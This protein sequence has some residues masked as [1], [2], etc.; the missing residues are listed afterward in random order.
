[1]F[2]KQTTLIAIQ[3]KYG[4]GKDLTTSIIQE[5]LEPDTK[6]Y[7]DNELTLYNQ[8]L[9]GFLL[10]NFD[11]EPY[12]PQYKEYQWQNK[13]FATKLKEIVSMLTGYTLAELEL[14]ETKDI[15]L[16]SYNNI[17]IR[18]L[19]QQ[20]GTNLRAITED[21]WINV[22]FKD[23]QKR[24][25]QRVMKD[26]NGYPYSI[27]TLRNNDHWIISDLRYKN[28][29]KAIKDR[30]GVLIRINRESNIVQQCSTLAH[31]DLLTKF[32]NDVFDIDNDDVEYY[33]EDMQKHYDELYDKYFEIEQLKRNHISET[34]LDD[35]EGFDFII[36]NNGTIEDLREKVKDILKQLNLIK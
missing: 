15:R 3:G 11:Y 31:N 14:R 23:Y 10:K 4:S 22:L 6:A 9:E 2:D 33:K 29:A 19:M 28:E 24:V 32:G 16:S 20:V 8:S 1:M 34:D 5:L 18:E 13:K 12:K 30:G 17:T 7:N 21:I 26:K 36:D 27:E 35:Y 25:G